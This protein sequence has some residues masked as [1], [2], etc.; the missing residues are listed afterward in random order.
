M[1]HVVEIKSKTAE[2]YCGR[3]NCYLCGKP[4]EKT[5]PGSIVIFNRASELKYGLCI[6]LD[7]HVNFVEWLVSISELERKA[8]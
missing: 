6:C 1:R 5:K 2:P 3:F 8:T 7:C 4:H